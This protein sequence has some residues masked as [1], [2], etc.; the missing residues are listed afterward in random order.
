[1]MFL[2]AA[3]EREFSVFDFS[4]NLINWLVLVA[5][6]IWL[7]SKTLPGVFANRKQS[8]ENEL[9][10][11]ARARAE[12]AAFLK[13]Q[14]AKLANAEKEADQILVEAK[15]MADSLRQEIEQQAEKEAAELKNRLEQEIVNHRQQAVL[16]LRTAATK[17]AITL[18]QATLPEAISAQTKRRLMDDFVQQVETNNG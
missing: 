13:E 3:V 17:A 14:E 5:L 4:N 12:G 1:M 15:Q 7:C 2:F 8:I 9:S 6:I 11:A 10:E 16:H 18:T